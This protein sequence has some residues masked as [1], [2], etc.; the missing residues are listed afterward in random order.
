MCDSAVQ[1]MNAGN[2]L[3]DGI[4]AILK[5]GNHTAADHTLINESMSL[6]KSQLGDQGILVLEVAVNALYIGQEG[7]LLSLYCLCDRAGCVI[8]I[9][10]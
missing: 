8:C 10:I 2:T 3:F 6:V 4:D 9:D 7:Q 5:L 1:N